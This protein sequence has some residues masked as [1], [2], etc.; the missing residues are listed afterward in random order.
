MKLCN[1]QFHLQ[2]FLS[3][4][5][6]HNNILLHSSET[7]NA[8]QLPVFLLFFFSCFFSSLIQNI[9]E[10]RAKKYFLDHEIANTNQLFVPVNQKFI[11]SI[12]FQI[13]SKQRRICQGLHDKYSHLFICLSLKQTLSS[14]QKPVYTVKILISEQIDFVAVLYFEQVSV[15][16]R[17]I[18]K[19]LLEWFLLI[20]CQ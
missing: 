3:S 11:E 13:K 15:F 2:Y 18:T 5:I 4:Q 17:L 19:N 8:L 1:T 16:F 14:R 12:L 6:T 7:H 10:F 20:I 9:R